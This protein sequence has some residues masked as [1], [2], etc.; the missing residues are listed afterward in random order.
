MSGLVDR[1]QLVFKRMARVGLQRRERQKLLPRHHSL[2]VPRTRASSLSTDPALR[3]SK[4]ARLETAVTWR[5]A[6]EVA[7]VDLD[8]PDCSWRAKPDDRPVVTG[9]AT[10]PRLPAIA[11][12]PRVAWHDEVVARS[13]KHVAA[14]DD[15]ASVLHC[16]EIDLAAPP[17]PRPIRHDVAVDAQPRDAAVRIDPQPKMRRLRRAVDG[18]QVVGGARER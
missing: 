17:Q 4:R 2:I 10:P 7:R 12:V 15:H 9:T 8:A 5:V 13:E 18:Q 3:W 14:R 11:H 6:F 16:G 1:L